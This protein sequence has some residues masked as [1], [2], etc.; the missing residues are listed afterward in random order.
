MAAVGSR[1]GGGHP[2]VKGKEYVRSSANRCRRDRPFSSSTT[3]TICRL[4]DPD[5]KKQ[6]LDHRVRPWLVGLRQGRGRTSEPPAR[7]AEAQGQEA[8]MSAEEQ[9]ARAGRVPRCDHRQLQSGSIYPPAGDAPG[10]DLF[11]ALYKDRKRRLHRR[12][13]AT[14]RRRLGKFYAEPRRRAQARRPKPR[15]AER[16]SRR[17]QQVAVGPA[18]AG[19]PPRGDGGSGRGHRPPRLRAPFLVAAARDRPGAFR[20]HGHER[21]SGG[22]TSKHGRRAP[23]VELPPW[24]RVCWSSSAANMRAFRSQAEKADC[25]APWVE[26]MTEDRREKIARSLRIGLEAFKA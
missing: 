12:P 1:A 6:V 18:G 25:P 7:T 26:V 2:S 22:A 21:R 20:V 14:L 24:R 11:R 4:I 8:D 19:E 3:P 17:R 16:R 15:L 10:K 23:G 5:T 13:G 9:R